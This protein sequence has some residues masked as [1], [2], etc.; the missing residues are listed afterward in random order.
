M[1]L[2]Q[3]LAD[4]FAQRPGQWV[5][6]RLLADVAGAYAWRSRCADLRRPP[7]SLTIE[8]RQRTM[9][10][11]TGRKFKVSEYRLVPSTPCNQTDEASCATSAPFSAV[12]A[13][14]AR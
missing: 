14:G 12:D 13:A 9:R 3:R 2:C 7:F 1:S 11:S 4:Y 6:G 8:N 10:S 5:D